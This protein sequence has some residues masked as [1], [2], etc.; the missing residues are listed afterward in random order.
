ME[1]GDWMTDVLVEELEIWEE[2]WL[3]L[4]EVAEMMLE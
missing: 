4:A 1:S 3:V 2:E